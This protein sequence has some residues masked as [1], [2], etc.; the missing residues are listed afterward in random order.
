M[1]PSFCK[2]NVIYLCENLLCT[3]FSSQQIP[4]IKLMVCLLPIE[5]FS[6]THVKKHMSY[7]Q[8]YLSGKVFPYTL[9]SRSVKSLLGPIKKLR[10]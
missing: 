3:K 5:T 7:T 4:L 1:N 9:K 6:N 8:D 2:K 10:K